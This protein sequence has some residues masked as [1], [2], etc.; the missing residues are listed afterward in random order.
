MKQKIIEKINNEL[1]NAAT[2]YAQEVEQ[3]GRKE[4]SLY[5][6][7]RMAHINGMIEALEI[8]TGKQYAIDGETLKEI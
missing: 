6:C 4:W 8:I 7:Q 5:H 1:H 3:T 2:K